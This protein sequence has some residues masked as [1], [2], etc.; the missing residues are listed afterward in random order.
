MII[1]FENLPPGFADTIAQEPAVPA[2]ASPAATVVLLRDSERG[3]EVLLLKR[4]RAS[5]FV[6]GAYVFPGGRVDAADSDERLIATISAPP[7]APPLMYWLAAVREVF[8]ETGALLACDRGGQPAVDAHTDPALAQWREALLGD[9]ATLRDVL[10]DRGLQP[11]LRQVVYC[12]HWIT[13]VVE[14]RR[15]DTRFFAAALPPGQAAH[16]D[17]REMSDALW[18]TPADALERFH[19]G[20]LPMV[21]PTVRTLQELRGHDSVAALLASLAGGAVRT[22]LP[23]LIRS[24]AGV[25]LVVD[26]VGS[27][28]IAVPGSDLSAPGSALKAEEQ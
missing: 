10:H 24:A 19:E 4:H 25:E 16:P 18:L 17:A 2:P 13:P 23:R 7:L 22:I 1:P 28:E 12:A 27:I 15:Y 26:Y 8:E 11:D 6:P 20:G 9:Q 5:G 21:F 14:P 3:P